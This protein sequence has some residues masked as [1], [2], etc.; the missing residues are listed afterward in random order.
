MTMKKKENDNVYFYDT[1]VLLNHYDKIFNRKETF[2]LS[3]IT[4][5]ELER[6]KTSSNKDEDVKYAARRVVHLLHENEDKY[7]IHLHD[8]RDENQVN[9]LGFVANDDLRIIIDCLNSY[10]SIR[11]EHQVFVTDDLC[12][13]LIAKTQLPE[14]CVKSSKDIFEEISDEYHGYTEFTTDEGTASFY[15]E[16]QTAP[17][18]LVNEYSIIKCGEITDCYKNTGTEMKKVPYSVFN[19]STFGE[20][21][22]KDVY[23]QAAM[24]SMNSNQITLLGGPAGSGKTYLA[25]GYLFMLL[26]K[27]K[28][29]RIVVFCNPVAARN[30]AK[31][32]FYPGTVIEKLMSTQVGKVLS[33]KLGDAFG[34][35]QLIYDG[36]LVLVPAADARGYEVPP[37]SGVYVLESQN[38]TVDLLRMILQRIGEDSKVIV[39]GDRMEQVD[40]A[41]YG[42]ANNGMRE[43]SR[44]FRGEEIYGQVDLKTIYRSKIASIADKMR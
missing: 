25:L 35:E 6:I 9:S 42:G 22:A 24:D 44:V 2:Y 20:I 23:Q 34:V 14:S 1:N 16:M 30:A 33:S 3:S 18:G 40:V 11:Q 15:S 7:I 29:D 28:I 5:Q 13:A 21:K 19:S 32:G 38:L 4:I 36:K 27:H 43:M 17:I 26:D 41:V 8:A 37:H 12:C 10:S 31:L 39:D